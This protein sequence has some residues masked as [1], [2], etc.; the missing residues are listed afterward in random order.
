VNLAWAESPLFFLK[1]LFYIRYNNVKGKRDFNTFFILYT[2]LINEHFEIAKKCIPLIPHYGSFKDLLYFFGT[3]LEFSVIEWYASALNKDLLILER[4]ENTKE[5]VS[6]AAK[7]A[8]SEGMSHDKKY[9]SVKKLSV[10]MGF[11][12]KNSK[13]LYRKRI[14]RLREELKVTERLMCLDRWKDINYSIVSNKCMNNNAPLFSKHD[15]DRFD[16]WRGQTKRVLIKRNLM[17]HEVV[18]LALNRNPREINV[19]VNACWEKSVRQMKHTFKNSLVIADLSDYMSSKNKCIAISLLLLYLENYGG[20]FKGKLLR[21][22]KDPKLLTIF[23]N[24]NDLVS[25]VKALLRHK[26]FENTEFSFLSMYTEL[27]DICKRECFQRNDVPS[28]IYVVSCRS[29]KETDNGGMFIKKHGINGVYKDIVDIK[30]MFRESGFSLPEL[31][32]INLSGKYTRFP[33]ESRLSNTILLNGNNKNLLK[34]VYVEKI[35]SPSKQLL[36]LLQ[37]KCFDLIDTTYLYDTSTIIRKEEPI[38][39]DN[40]NNNEEILEITEHDEYIIL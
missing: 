40:D 19:D 23:Q 21:F 15:A 22:V 17:P 6:L 37:N 20:Y 3:H 33:E 26:N 5:K 30:K 28:K 27:L 38:S 10:A 31:V 7:W 25:R 1:L 36:K 12:V 2:W 39:N 35:A 18:D 11:P 16:K 32:F 14:S 4:G 13:E 34:D 29:F 8:P 24:D 9:G